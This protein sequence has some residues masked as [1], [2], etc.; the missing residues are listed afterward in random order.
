MV[1]G[2]PYA[3]RSL[4]KIKRQL[5]F[6]A[7]V[8]L[9]STSTVKYV[10]V[11]KARPPKETWWNNKGS[12]W[13]RKPGIFPP[14]PYHAS[15]PFPLFL[16]QLCYFQGLLISPTQL[17]GMFPHQKSVTVVEIFFAPTT[18]KKLLFCKPQKVIHLSPPIFCVPKWF[19]EFGIY[20]KV[21]CFKLF[22]SSKVYLSGL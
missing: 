20:F 11:W 15:S 13:Q 6:I 16:F 19:P 2:V 10:F 5:R 1:T 4:V 8:F 14:Y 22:I 3:V 7:W 12:S 17:R 21:H 9:S 18:L